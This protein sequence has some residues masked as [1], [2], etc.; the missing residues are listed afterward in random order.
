MQPFKDYSIVSCRRAETSSSSN[1]L[2]F[3]IQQDASADDNMPAKTHAPCQLLTKMRSFNDGTKNEH[4][5][6]IISMAGYFDILLL[7]SNQKSQ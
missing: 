2:L 3:V 5:H 6:A 7:M 1:L 4:D